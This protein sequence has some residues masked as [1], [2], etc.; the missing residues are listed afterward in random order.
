MQQQ[1]TSLS[2]QLGQLKLQAKAVRLEPNQAPPSLLF[3]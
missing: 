3:S 2:A 1:T